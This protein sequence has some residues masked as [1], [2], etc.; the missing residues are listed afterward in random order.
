MISRYHIRCNICQAPH[1]LRVQIGYGEQKHRFQCHKC[2]EPIFF[3]LRS[4]ENN[5]GPKLDGAIFCDPIDESKEENNYQYLS[6]D[7]VAD[8]EEAKKPFYFGAIDLMREMHK[9]VQIQKILKQDIINLPSGEHQWFAQSDAMPDLEVLLRCWRLERSGKQSLATTQLVNHFGEGEYASVWQSIL[10]F[11][12]KLFGCN[13]AL[14]TEVLDIREKNRD[15]FARL[16]VAYTNHWT[17]DF[18]DGQLQVFSEFYKKWADFSQV[19]LYVKNEI[20]MPNSPMATT[21]NFDEVRGFYSLAQEFFSKQVRLLTAI[22][23]IKSGRHFNMLKSISLDKYN[24][25]DNAKRC[26]NF[27]DNTVFMKVCNEYDSE[28]RN[29]EAHNWIMM[30]TT[31]NLLLY[32]KGGKGEEVRLTYVSYLLKCTILFKQICWLMHVEFLLGEDARGMAHDLLST[33]NSKF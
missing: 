16:V 31:G 5:G 9:T 33:P 7:F 22:N 11:T 18:R 8:E 21:V 26:A 2:N 17:E 10:N 15:E 24:E 1:T 4:G 25:S 12:D 28:L 14:M 20:K 13:H 19:Y 6:P 23:N 29:A 30:A 32:K 27:F 3:E